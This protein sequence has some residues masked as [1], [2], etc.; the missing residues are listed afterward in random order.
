MG[1]LQELCSGS[2]CHWAY[3][4][5]SLD[6]GDPPEPSHVANNWELAERADVGAPASTYDVPLVLENEASLNYQIHQ[7]IDGRHLA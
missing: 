4:Y 6:S 2:P 5:L 7:W 3:T 1:T